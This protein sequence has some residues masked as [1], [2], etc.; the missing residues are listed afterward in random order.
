MASA[1]IYFGLVAREFVD[2]DAL[3]QHGG[4]LCI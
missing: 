1:E 3:G 4:A 2:V